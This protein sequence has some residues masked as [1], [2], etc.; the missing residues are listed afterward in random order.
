MNGLRISLRLASV[1]K[2]VPPGARMA[3]IGTDHAYLPIHLVLERKIKRAIAG[4][5]NE[6]PYQA[7]VKQVQKFGLTHAIDVRKGDGLAIIRPDEADVI[8][9][10][11]MG[12]AL[13]RHILDEGREKLSGVHRLILQPN[14]GAE[15][16]RRWLIEREWELKDEDIVEEDE[17]TYEILMAEP[18]DPHK[19]YEGKIGVEKEKAVLMGPF[20]LQ[21]KTKS[22]VRRWRN[23]LEKRCRVI[24]SMEQA[25][26]MRVERKKARIWQEIQMIKEE[27]PQ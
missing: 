7:A 16:L 23:E 17:K 14:V 5:V 15:R 25:Q 21:K 11:G 10:A 19:P 12:G 1:A 9:L 26:E 22:F 20:L 8:V 18:G 13:I 4:E 27:L 2:F 3:D 6:G 24:K